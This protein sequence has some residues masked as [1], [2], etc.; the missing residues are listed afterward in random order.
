SQNYSGSSAGSFVWTASANAV[1]SR[2][3]RQT[4]INENTL[5][6]G[7]GQTRIQDKNTGTWSSPVKSTDY[8]N[9]I[10]VLKFN[11]MYFKDSYLSLK[12][13]SCF[14][15]DRQKENKRY[16]NPVETIESFGIQRKLFN[17]KEFSWKID[18][19]GALRQVLDRHIKDF[20]SLGLN[21]TY[22]NN[23]DYDGGLEFGSE[24]TTNKNNWLLLTSK[25]YTYQALFCP[26]KE[27][28]KLSTWYYPDIKWDNS[29][30]VCLT[31]FLAFSY[32]MQI[33][34]NKDLDSAP[35]I[36]QHFG[37]SFLLDYSH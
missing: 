4:A 31:P 13:N 28:T 37:I 1:V 27:F 15:D 21:Y 17:K 32:T 23:F 9:F 29:V 16:L 22:K 19:G 24:I 11:T 33:T 8:M 25:L 12:I 7:F 36:K 14:M 6:I 10:S 5:K 30:K 35:F 3:F 2:T 18:F 20:D 34:F 26:L